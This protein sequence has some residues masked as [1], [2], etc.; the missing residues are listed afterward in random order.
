[1]LVIEDLAVASAYQYHRLRLLHTFMATRS[2][3][4]AMRA[5]GVAMHYF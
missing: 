2:L 3:R 5:R 4:D 1:V